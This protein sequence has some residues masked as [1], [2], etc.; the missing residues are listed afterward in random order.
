MDYF[1]AS[2]RRLKSYSTK[3]SSRPGQG[4]LPSG[5]DTGT[6]ANILIEL[7]GERGEVLIEHLPGDEQLAV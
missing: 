4:A 7:T 5:D 2:P 6:Q 3:R 1:T